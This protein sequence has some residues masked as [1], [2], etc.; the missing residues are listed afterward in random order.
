MR[1]YLFGRKKRYL[2]LLLVGVAIVFVKLKISAVS[3]DYIFLITTPASLVVVFE[4]RSF[5]WTFV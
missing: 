3:L 2:L 1:G 4:R 5:K